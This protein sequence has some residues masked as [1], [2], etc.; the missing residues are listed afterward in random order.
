MLKKLQFNIYGLDDD[1]VLICKD[2]C[3]P[4]NVQNIEFALNNYRH[5]NGLTLADII[6]HGLVDINALVGVDFISKLFGNTI[7]F[8]NSGPVALKFN[9]GGCVFSGCSCKKRGGSFSVSTV[10]VLKVQSEFIDDDIVLKP[11]LKE[12]WGYKDSCKEND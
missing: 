7:C 6:V 11:S 9:L 3:A 4:I 8:G 1:T 12:M 5:L 2:I 10:Q